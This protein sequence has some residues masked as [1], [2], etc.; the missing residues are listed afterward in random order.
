MKRFFFL[1][2]LLISF[3][4][5]QIWAD[6]VTFNYLDYKGKGTTS[7]GSEYTMSDKDDVT[8][9]DTKFYGNNSYAHFYANSVVTITPAE[10]VT[11][12]NLVLTASSK[13]YNGYQSNGS[14]T[15][16]TGVITNTDDTHVTWTGSATSAFTISHNKQI[17]W[18]SIVVTYTKSESTKTLS[19]V[20]VSGTPTKTSYNTGDNFDPAGLTVTGTYSDASTAPITSGI[21]WSYNPS[22]TLALNQT[23]IGVTATV[24]NIASAEFNVT[25]LTVTDPVVSTWQVIAPSDLVTG[26]VVVLTMLKNSVYYAAPNNGGN[27]A[28]TATVVAVTNNKLSNA[29]AETLQWTVTV[30]KEGV[31][32]FSVGSNYLKCTDTNNGVKVGTDDYNTFDINTTNEKQYLHTTESMTNAENGRYLGI[33]NTQD[34]RCYSSVN[35]N[36]KDG[37]LVIFKDASAAVVVAKPTIS[38]DENFVTSATVTITQTNADAIYYTTNGDAPT[39]NSTAYTAPFSLTNTA[40]VKA[41]AVKG[42]DVSDVAEKTFTKATPITVTEA[43]AAIPNQDDV[44]DNQFVSGIVCTAGTSV[45]ASGQMTY[46]ISDDGSETSR[47][48]IYLGKNLNNT[49]FSAVSDLAIGDRVVVF[50]QLKNYKGTK[51]M[52][53]GNYLISKADP[54]VAA[55]TFTPDGGGFMG[56]TDVTITCATAN[57][58]IYYTLDGSAPSKSSTQ[59]TA[60]IHLTATTTIKAIAFVGN[61]ASLVISKTFTL[62]APMTVA[63][64]LTAL[65]SENPKNNVAVAGIISTAPTSNPNSGRLTYYI[66]DDGSTTDQLEVYLGFGLNGASFSA[67]TDLQVGDEVTVF[68]NLKIYNETKEFDAGNRLLAFNRPTVAVSSVSLPATASV[69]VGKTVTLTATVLPENASDK[70]ITWTIESGSDKASVDGGVV[71][72]TAEGTAVIRATS[73]ADNTKYAECTVTVTAASASDTRNIANSPAT[74]TTTNGNLDP[75]DIAYA[76]Y[77]GGSSTAPAIYND[78]IRLYQISGS[79]TFGGFITL[80]AKL[81]CTIDEVQIT[82]TSKYATTVAYSVDGNETLSESESVAASS[83]YTTGT[84]LN[85]SSVNILNLG[86][87]SNGRLEIASIKVYYTGEAAA[88]DHYELGGTYA[89]EFEV[90]DE[91]NH[92]GLIVYAAFDASGENKSDITSSCTFSTPDMSTEGDKT[93]EITYNDAVVKSYTITVNA[94]TDTRKVAESPATFTTVSG[95]MTPND[96]TFASDQGGASTAPANY[97]DGIR[98]YQAPSVDKIGGYITLKAKK[99]CTID[100]VKITTTKTYATTVAYSV[101][102]NENLLGSESVAKSSDYSTPSGLNVESVNIVNKGTGSSG[103]LEIASIKVWYTGDALAVHHYILGGTY[104]TVFEQFGTFSYEG[105]TV[106]AAYDAGAT[107]TEAVTGFTVEADLSTAGAKKA[108]VMLNSVKIAEYDITVNASA[109]TDPALAYSPASVILTLGDAL[110]APTFS[111]TYNVSPITYSSDKPAVATVDAEG[112]ISLAGGTGVAVITASFAGDDDYIESEATFTITV[113]EPVEDLTGTWVK[114]TTVAA[115]DRIIIAGTYNSK[116]MAMGKQ[117]SNNRAAVLSTLDNDV[118]TPGN[119]TKVFTLVDA[120]EGLFAI[121]ASNGKYLNAAGTGDKNYLKEADDYDAAS[122]KW[123]ITFDENGANIVATSTDNRNVIRYNSSN[124]SELFSCY[125]AGGQRAINIYKIG[126]YQRSGLTVGNYGTICLPNGGTISGAK[127]FDLEYYDGANTLYFLEVNGNAMEAGRPY[128]FLPSATTIEVTYTDNA[129]ASAGNYNGL[130]GSY[131]QQTIATGDGNYILYQNAY[132]LVNSTAYV[133]ANRAYIHMAD[134]PD[135]PTGD[136]PR[137]RVAMAVNGE[138]VAT[139]I[140]AINASDKPM[141]VMIDGKLYIIRAGQMYDMTGSKVK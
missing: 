38:G 116:T 29:P 28:P 83:S 111:N 106:T 69:E 85:T 79:N 127:L 12:S 45:N 47:L 71:T 88:I 98:L 65:D 24:S 15:T 34:W 103:R 2:S 4:I 42:T 10:N 22:Q 96:I 133:G 107:I 73:A 16:S 44:V 7:S 20:A 124:G 54:A 128:I 109:K 92:N 137:R 17:R 125:A 120:G 1:L 13:S 36:I 138:Q 66:S 49:A 93:I 139:G 59:Y 6:D 52:N 94:S 25:G 57:S 48:Q 134:V 58:T 95:D 119:E 53:S 39:T 78:G 61:D 8:I 77:Q 56:E 30:V 26:D 123:T 46:Y 37:S 117:N 130:V 115:G 102:G 5:G 35:N 122:A 76:S 104:E 91:F 62:T 101:D 140:D 80:T 84:D 112:N 100:Q 19:S 18:T 3:S 118:L 32:Q 129:N 72:G 23:S 113:N 135:T 74:F 14:V 114:A 131:S 40:T 97:N 63:E 89:T 126:S 75:A 51:E 9:S 31:Y 11:I 70:S 81:G 67:K 64:A 21:T 82:T 33:Y 110:S 99:G 50:G 90:G 108:E 136:A 68:G 141:K 132:Y 27:N 121:Q 86:S 105:L 55:P 87:G 41:I 43:I 60:A